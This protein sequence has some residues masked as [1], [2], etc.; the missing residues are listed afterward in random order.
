MDVVTGAFGYIGRYITAHLLETGRQ[1]KTITTHVDKPN[2]FGTRVR[3]FPYD[4]E[5]PDRLVET[6]RG[7]DTLYNTYWVRFP[8]GSLTFEDAV[9]NT[10]ILFNSAVQAGVRKIVHISVTQASPESPLPYYAGKGRQE[11]IL[12][13]T[14]IPYA[15]V[16][17]TLVFGRED[18]LLNNI[19]WLMRKFPLFA[20][21][22]D[23]SYR[24]QPV[25]VG[26]LAKIAVEQASQQESGTIDAIGPESYSYRELVE[27]IARAI[28][29]K[30]AFVQMSPGLTI[31]LGRIA[32]LFVRDVVLTSNELKG[33]MGNYLTSNQAPNGETKLSDWLAENS[34]TVGAV[35]S[36]ELERHFRWRP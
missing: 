34:Q 32:G 35:Y 29:K 7:V 26:D 19:A 31:F 23:G 33:L 10:K 14:G 22:G 9:A 11:E 2:P 15:I 5:R 20:I 4:F 28:D 21:A 1:V 13:A 3:A 12:K 25:F 27:S 18:I 24:L 8:H 6:L 17:P 30:V 36:S 16:R